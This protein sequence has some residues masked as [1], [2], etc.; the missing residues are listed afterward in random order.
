VP[1]LS[2]VLAAADAQLQQHRFAHEG[3]RPRSPRRVQHELSEHNEE[4]YRGRNELHQAPSGLQ[5]EQK[6]L[7]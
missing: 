3:R 7:R 6:A 4:S 5:N 1:Q 2:R